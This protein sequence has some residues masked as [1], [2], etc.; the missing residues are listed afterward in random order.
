VQPGGYVTLLSGAGFDLMLGV[1]PAAERA[2]S[3]VALRVGAT[4]V[5]YTDGLVERR[6]RTLDEGFDLICEH[7]ADLAER[8]LDDLCDE[9]LERMVRGVPQD[10]VALVA[11]RLIGPSDAA[12][13]KCL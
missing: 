5:L 13:G 2:E 6:G 1:D 12:C 7:L 8:P 3:A 10:D 9:L 11:L 4:V